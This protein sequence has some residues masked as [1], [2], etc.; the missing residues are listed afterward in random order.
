MSRILKVSGGD[1]RLQVQTGGNII[2]DTQ[3]TN[4]KVLV[5]GNLDVQGALTFVES[6][7]TQITDNIIQLNVGQTGNG[8]GAVNSYVSGIEVARGN[9]SPA[10]IIFNEQ[11]SHYDS[12]SSS[13]V[14]GSWSARTAD[15]K[16]SGIQLR[17]ITNDGLADIIFD[18]QNQNPV[19]RI[20]NST[21]YYLRCTNVNDIPNIDYL[22]HY[23]ASTYTGSGQGVAIVDRVLYPGTAGTTVSNAN[24]SLQASSTN[25][26]FQVAQTTISTI[27][28]SG[29]TT[30]NVRIGGGTGAQLNTITNTTSNN[31]IL[32]STNGV[33][34]VNAVMTLDDQTAP[35]YTSGKSKVYSSATA[36]PGRTGIYFTNSTSQ[37]PDELISRS[38]AVLLSIL[39]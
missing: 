1:Y 12:Q 33:V 32:T 6:T 11:V 31:L 29:L 13:T 37:T 27:S 2:L 8:I 18:L 7:N 15:G 21:N 17:T 30:G 25:I 39:L 22:Q 16:L 23:V 4:G 34:E 19:L 14:S 20:A 38:R 5:I 26:V 24:T 36:G 35:T 9:Y 10:Q 3:S 28:S